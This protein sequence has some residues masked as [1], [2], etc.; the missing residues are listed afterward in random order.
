MR[1]DYELIKK[2]SRYVAQ[3]E[4]LLRAQAEQ[5]MEMEMEQ[6]K[7]RDNLEKRQREE[8]DNL[9]KRQREEKLEKEYYII[10]NFLFEYFSK[11]EIKDRNPQE[12]KKNESKI[13]PLN[14]AP[15]NKKD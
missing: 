14:E 10:F 6:R 13:I 12:N 9:E 15:D 11:E 1:E 3:K 8:R 5:R 7:E 4:N 2:Y